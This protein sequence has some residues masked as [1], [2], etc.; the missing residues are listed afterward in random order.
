MGR[1]VRFYPQKGC[2]VRAGFT[3]GPYGLGALAMVSL[4][5]VEEGF[6]LHTLPRP[7]EVFE[8]PIDRLGGPVG[9]TGPVEVGEDVVRAVFQYAAESADLGQRGR[10][11]VADR[12]DHGAH[13]ILADGLVQR[14][15]GSDHA[16]VDSPGRFD[17]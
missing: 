9:R 12:V 4:N 3:P 15:V 5:N 7:A 8:A 16:L 14:P 11:A 1:I 6:E 10:D 17:F 2:V 13:L